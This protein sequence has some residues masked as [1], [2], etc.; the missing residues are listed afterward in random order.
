[1]LFQRNVFAFSKHGKPFLLKGNFIECSYDFHFVNM[2][3]KDNIFLR[4]MLRSWKVINP[5]GNNDKNDIFHNVIWNHH[6]I[7]LNNIPLFYKKWYDKGVK[8]LWQL[9]D[10]RINKLYSFSDIQFIYGIKRNDFI[11]YKQLTLSIPKTII[12]VLRKN[13]FS[14][15]EKSQI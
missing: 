8:Y 7:K 9:F 2:I 5:N 13:E 11:K 4:D 3:S 6:S 12:D 14:P 10:F 15:N 1:M